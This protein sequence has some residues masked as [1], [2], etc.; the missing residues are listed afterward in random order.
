MAAHPLKLEQFVPRFIFESLIASNSLWWNEIIRHFKYR[1][2]IQYPFVAKRNRRNR[3]QKD[4]SCGDASRERA[5]LH[6]GSRKSR[7]EGREH[8]SDILKLGWNRSTSVVEVNAVYGSERGEGQERE[9]EEDDR[10]DSIIG[11][12]VLVDDLDVGIAV[13]RRRSAGAAPW[14][15]NIATDR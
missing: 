4:P 6:C 3:K 1:D 12:V 8:T 7:S 13:P 9:D 2:I 15:Q 11:F 5:P 14:P 10:H